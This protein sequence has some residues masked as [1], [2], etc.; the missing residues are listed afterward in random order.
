MTF[1]AKDCKEATEVGDRRSSPTV[2]SW[3]L[4]FSLFEELGSWDFRGYLGLEL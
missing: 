4:G 3:G 2:V 1:L